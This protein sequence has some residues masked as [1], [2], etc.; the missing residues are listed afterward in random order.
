MSAPVKFGG[1]S[2]D[3]TIAGVSAD[4][5]GFDL[6]A[7]QQVDDATGYTDDEDTYNAGSGVRDWTL[8][9]NGFAITTTAVG[10]GAISDTAAAVVATPT[11]GKTYTGSFVVESLKISSKKISGATPISGRAKNQGAVVE[12]WA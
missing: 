6:E 10:L 7:R 2:G 3:L 11:T 4:F 9:F 5:S 1:G 12:A 8:D